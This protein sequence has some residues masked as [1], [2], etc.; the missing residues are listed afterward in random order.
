MAA[1][2]V[3]VSAEVASARWREAKQQGGRAF[4]RRSTC[5]TSEY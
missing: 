4:G 1:S 3:A 5:V 2:S